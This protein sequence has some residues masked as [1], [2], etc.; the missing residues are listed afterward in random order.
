MV[1]FQTEVLFIMSDRLRGLLEK[2]LL[3]IENGATI[4]MTI[5]IRATID[6]I[7]NTTEYE[8][9]A[10]RQA[11]AQGETAGQESGFD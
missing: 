7:G 8:V 6:R 1:Y 5:S 4:W 9:L 2:L 11:D 10:V 3:I